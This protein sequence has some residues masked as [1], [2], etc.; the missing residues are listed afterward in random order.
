MVRVWDGVAGGAALLTLEGHTGF[1]HAVACHEVGGG[2]WCVVSGSG[3]NT[4]RVWDGAAG[5]VAL[6]TLEG[7]TGFVKAVACHD[8]GGGAWR[9]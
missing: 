5:G 4:V 9:V 7:H 3:D 6:L 2:A 8:V 1:V